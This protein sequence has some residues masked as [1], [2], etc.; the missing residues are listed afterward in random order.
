MYQH[1]RDDARRDVRQLHGKPRLEFEI[2]ITARSGKGHSLRH[3][4]G[5]L[6]ADGAYS[7]ADVTRR[8]RHNT[9]TLDVY[10]HLVDGQRTG[11]LSLGEALH[12][13]LRE[14]RKTVTGLRLVGKS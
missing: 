11:A 4:Y 1:G 14:Y 12:S 6:L 2:R 7:L 10:T 5:S 8:M 3:L 9:T 13:G